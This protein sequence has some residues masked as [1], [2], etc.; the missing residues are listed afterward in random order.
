MH[1]L[2]PWPPHQAGATKEELENLKA[3]VAPLDTDGTLGANSDTRVASQKAT[4]TY[5]DAIALAGVA[6]FAPQVP[7]AIF[8]VSTPPGYI[9]NSFVAGEKVPIMARVICPRA[10][11]LK[12]LMCF[13]KTS[14]GNV[15]M[16]IYDT[17]DAEAGKRTRLFQSGS[18]AVGVASKWQVVAAEPNITVKAGQELDLYVVFDSATV[19]LGR[20]AMASGNGLVLPANYNKVP[21]G[22]SPKLSGTTVAIAAIAELPATIAEATITTTANVPAVAC[23][24]E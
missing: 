24:V 13:P 2:P 9:G 6:A 4:K 8:P 7:G 18:V 20:V 1:P 14:A 5:G 15:A 17:G 16:G 21:G 12:D 10:G 11:K 22:A 3:E 23:R 19:E